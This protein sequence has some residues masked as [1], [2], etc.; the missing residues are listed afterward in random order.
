MQKTMPRLPK[1]SIKTILHFCR[2]RPGNVKL[3]MATLSVSFQSS[4]D[5]KRLAKAPVYW[6]GVFCNEPGNFK[7]SVKVWR[8]HSCWTTFHC[9]FWVIV[10]LLP[11]ILSYKAAGVR[12]MLNSFTGIRIYGFDRFLMLRM[13]SMFTGRFIVSFLSYPRINIDDFKVKMATLPVYHP[14][15]TNVEQLS[16]NS[17]ICIRDVFW[18]WG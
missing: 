10:E 6:Q 17:S 11:R 5:V 12:L 3:K 13:I 4:T 8:V 15:S 1:R 2:I 9:Q 7:L 16:K 14:L 18:G